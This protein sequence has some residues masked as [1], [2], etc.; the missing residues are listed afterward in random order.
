MAE[1]IPFEW[2]FSVIPERIQMEWFIPVECF[3]KKRQYLSRCPFSGFYWN[4]RKFLYHLSILYLN[5]SRF[6]RRCFWATSKENTV[7]ADCSFYWRNVDAAADKKSYRKFHSNG[8]RSYVSIFKFINQGHEKNNGNF[9]NIS[10]LS[11]QVSRRCLEKCRLTLFFS[12]PCF[13]RPNLD[14]ELE[15]EKSDLT[16]P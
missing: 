2:F 9:P 13:H 12:F 14:E 3:W 16:W 5:D 15:L 6:Q 1:Q 4:S 10:L 11:R 7:D 8:K